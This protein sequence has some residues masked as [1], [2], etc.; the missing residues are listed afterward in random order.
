MG[1]PVAEAKQR[2]SAGE[3]NRWL[4]RFAAE[5][6]RK[7]TEHW[8]MAQLAWLLDLIPFRVWGVDPPKDML[9]KN[10]LLEFGTAEEM[11]EKAEKHE[12]AQAQHKAEMLKANLFAMF[13]IDPATGKAKNFQTQLPPGMQAQ[14]APP[15]TFPGQANA[16]PPPAAGPAPSPARKRVWTSSGSYSG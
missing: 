10:Y 4:A 16:P 12:A 7:K 13:G 9:I 11:A 14:V 15:A 3:F 1:L 8:Y 2:I 5:A 6:N